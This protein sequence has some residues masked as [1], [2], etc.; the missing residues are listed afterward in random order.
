[1]AGGGFW[2]GD[3]EILTSLTLTGYVRERHVEGFARTVS[4]VLLNFPGGNVWTAP[5]RVGDNSGSIAGFPLMVSPILGSASD[6]R[7]FLRDVPN[8]KRVRVFG[9]GKFDLWRERDGFEGG[10]GMSMS[11]GWDLAREWKE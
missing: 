4:E 9:G 6:V 11:F 10:D 7:G 5:G 1:M 8:M 3:G 2:S